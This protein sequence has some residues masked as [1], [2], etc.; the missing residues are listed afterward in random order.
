MKSASH[1]RSGCIAGAVV[2]AS[3][4]AC[5]RPINAAV[6]SYNI[7]VMRNK[8]GVA[9]TF[10][11]ITVTSPFKTSPISAYIGN[12]GTAAGS[13]KISAAG[14][15]T[16]A[17]GTYTAPDQPFVG[18]GGTFVFVIDNP[19]TGGVDTYS[20]VRGNGKAVS[21]EEEAAKRKAMQNGRGLA[22]G[23]INVDNAVFFDDGGSTYAQIDLAN[24]DTANNYEFTTLQ[25]YI[26][27][28]PVYFNT[29]NF[30]SSQ[31]MSTGTLDQDLS[32]QEL[33]AAASL[34]QDS[35]FSVDSDP[36]EAGT[37]QLL[38]GEAAPILPDG[39]LG[40]P[41]AF[42]EGVEDVPEPASLSALALVGAAMLGRRRRISGVAQ[43]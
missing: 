8:M 12:T 36:V 38:V 28:N 19:N 33:D 22:P 4:S 5:M 31:A 20:L 16:G 18:K 42:S 10:T 30:D 17:A 25:L 11:P 26:N 7:G 2:A 37:Y 13:T 1:F 43:E 21:K 9:T 34:S 3:L 14:D 24:Q 41:F 29:P 39:S 6:I 23:G 32:G 15:D 27:L 35:W 40:T